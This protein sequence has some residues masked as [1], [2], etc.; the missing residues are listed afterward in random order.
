MS[1]QLSWNLITLM[2]DKLFIN[3]LRILTFNLNNAYSE[4]DIVNQWQQQGELWTPS[5]AFF[6][7][8]QPI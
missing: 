5:L 3:D 4:I 7:F 1:M 2:K 6:Y 8:S